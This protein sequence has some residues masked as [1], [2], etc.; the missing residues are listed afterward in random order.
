[1]GRASDKSAP[2]DCSQKA[3]WPSGDKSGPISVICNLEASMAH[4]NFNNFNK[5]GASQWLVHAC[6][7]LEIAGQINGVPGSRLDR[8]VTVDSSE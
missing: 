2:S 3:D 5:R 7:W 4:G 8:S 1:M 6:N